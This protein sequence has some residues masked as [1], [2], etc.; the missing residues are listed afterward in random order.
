L[1]FASAKVDLC[2]KPMVVVIDSHDAKMWLHNIIIICTHSNLNHYNTSST[3]F[4][5][6]NATVNIT[7]PETRPY[8]R[9]LIIEWRHIRI[10][11]SRTCEHFVDFTLVYKNPR[12]N[13]LLAFCI[14][15]SITKLTT[16]FVLTQFFI[17][18]WT[19][20]L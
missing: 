5:R 6:K 19:K 3:E 13:V 17:A 4:G 12:W 8:H 1:M 14:R 16:P 15:R 11:C 9:L 18:I 20:Y 2:D 7:I 10:E